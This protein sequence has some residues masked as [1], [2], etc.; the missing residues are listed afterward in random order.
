[1]SAIKTDRVGEIRMQNC[2]LETE[3]I[4]YRSSADMDIQFSDG[5]IVEQK[6]Y[7]NFVKGQIQHPD[8]DHHERRISKQASERLGEVHMQ[9]CGLNAEIISYRHAAD[10]DVQFSDGTIVEH[11][12]YWDFTNKKIGHPAL[13]KY[14][15]ANIGKIYPQSKSKIYH[16]Q[17]HGVA[18]ILKDNIYHYYC[19]CPI[20]NTREIWTFDE[21]KDH[22][23]DHDIVRERDALIQIC[24]TVNDIPA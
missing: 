11:R 24:G 16:T 17:I 4:G 13:D 12:Q 8:A 18:Y 3:I 6:T 20:C 10:I 21:I 23:C 7:Q 19:H 22:K 14:F 1:M 15:S 5:R 2:G 9:N